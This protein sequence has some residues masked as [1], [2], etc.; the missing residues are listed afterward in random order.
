MV[1]QSKE[2]DV[3]HDCLVADGDMHLQAGGHLPQKETNLVHSRH[4]SA[5]SG[6]RPRGAGYA[7]LHPACIQLGH[8]DAHSV[9][10]QE[11]HNA[12]SAV[13]VSAVWQGD[14]GAARVQ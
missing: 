9:P 10:L 4:C 3:A 11:Q 12:V 1:G 2:L 14:A 7:P 6:N 8:T 5:E 13:G